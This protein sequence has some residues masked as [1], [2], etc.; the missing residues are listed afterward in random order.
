[1]HGG[2]SPSLLES[3]RLNLSNKN[4][5]EIEKNFGTE[6]NFPQENTKV[7][8]N[9]QNCQSPPASISSNKILFDPHQIKGINKAGKII[10]KD[11]KF[12]N[13]LNRYLNRTQNKG[14]NTE[15]AKSSSIKVIK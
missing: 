9:F 3:R 13:F 14:S 6:T 12:G 10:R 5:G 7:E 15:L 11:S 8:D 2:I 4:T 1:M